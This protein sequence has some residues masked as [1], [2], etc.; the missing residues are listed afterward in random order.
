MFILDY[1][2]WLFVKSG[3]KVQKFRRIVNITT[4]QKTIKKYF[5][6]KILFWNKNGK[7]LFPK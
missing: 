3:A 1:I 2:K 6:H 7:K 4:F 5:R